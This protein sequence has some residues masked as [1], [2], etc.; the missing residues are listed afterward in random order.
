MISHKRRVLQ[1]TDYIQVITTTEKRE[2]IQKLAK[3][4]VKKRLA[5]CAQVIGPIA[6]TYWWEKDIEEAEEWLLII[7]THK[8]LYRTLEN[9]IKEI[10]P[11]KV[12]EI[13]ALPVV[14]G[15]QDYLNWLDKEIIKRD[16]VP[17]L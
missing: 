9:A 6:S 16:R 5:A 10:H 1:M 12:P 15:N 14:D 17:S 3:E 4:V 8:D 7:K 13:M 11:Y 2:D